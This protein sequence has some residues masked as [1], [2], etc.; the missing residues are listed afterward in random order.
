MSKKAK[1]AISLS[2]L[3]MMILFLPGLPWSAASRHKLK[4]IID[5]AQLT[6]SKW[7]GHQPSLVSIAGETDVPGAR[8]FVLDSPSGWASLC[9]NQGRF[10]IPDVLWYPN[11]TYDLVVSSN[12]NIGLMVKI[13][14]PSD[15]PPTQVINAG[16]VLINIGQK[17]ELTDLAGDTSYSFEYFD[18]QNR[19]YYRNLFDQIT[20]DKLSDAEKVEAVNDYVATRLTYDKPQWELGSPRRI[21]EQGSQYCGHLS[22]TMTTLLAVAFPTRAVHLTDKS[23]PPNTHVVVEVFYEGDWHLYD[24][25][26]G[27]QFKN[28]QGEV[29]SYKELL[30]NPD[31]IRPELFSAFR[32]RYPKVPLNSVLGIYR[33]SYHHFYYLAYKGSQ[34]PHAWWAYK[35]GVNYVPT[36]GRVLLAAAGIQPGTKVVYHIRKPESELDELT[37][38]SK[39]GATSDNVLN[40]EE[41]PP[42]TLAAGS[43]EVF[44][45]LYDGNIPNSSDAKLAFVRD[46]RLGVKLEVK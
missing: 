1:A 9:D 38:V 26:F 34:Y 31:L 29:V 18:V 13:R 42:I 11:A 19:D 41:S 44:V 15:L 46:C 43:Y 37:F 7:S 23:T 14:A 25:T 33:S 30:L 10:T 21:L 5:K 27:V 24:P 40:E 39:C 32:Q 3:F 6:W 45:D 16:R 2:L 20:K 22:T 36:G 12:E 4:K 8:V 17:I 28:P 35:D